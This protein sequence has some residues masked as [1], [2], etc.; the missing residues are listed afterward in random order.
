MA[1]RFSSF[2][3]RDTPAEAHSLRIATAQL[4]ND[5]VQGRAKQ[6]EIEDFCQSL[7][8]ED[9][10][11]VTKPMFPA[12]RGETDEKI[13]A[14]DPSMDQILQAAQ[15]WLPEEQLPPLADDQPTQI[16]RVFCDVVSNFIRRDMEDKSVESRTAIALALRPLF[17]G[18][19][20]LLSLCE[21]V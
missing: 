15:Q 17:E 20:K 9:F 8:D 16:A 6:E 19:G 18:L 11:G 7:Q 14:E 13:S 21:Y 1:G 2:Q 12:L 10:Y 3:F 5:I 4:R